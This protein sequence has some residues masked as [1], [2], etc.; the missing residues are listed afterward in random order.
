[1]SRSKAISMIS[2]GMRAGKVRGGEF[3]SEEAV[4]NGKAFLLIIAEDAS[5]NTKKKFENMCAWY[6]V[7]A[8]TYGSKE[9]L[10]RAIG[11][12]PRATLAV[13]DEGFAKAIAENIRSEQGSQKE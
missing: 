7:P 11:K 8:L 5:A 3:A 2:L 13:Y 9:S 4:K 12:D 6:E 10:G 1:M